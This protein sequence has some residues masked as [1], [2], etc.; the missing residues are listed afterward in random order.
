MHINLREHGLGWNRSFAGMCGDSIKVLQV[1]AVILDRDG[2]SGD[3]NEI[4]MEGC[5]SL[6][7][8]CC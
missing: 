4:C 5:R 8:M 3:G 6:V 1:M 2:L 7:P